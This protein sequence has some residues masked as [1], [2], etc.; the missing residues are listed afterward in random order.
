MKYYVPLFRDKIPDMC[1]RDCR[2]FKRCGAGRRE[3][4]F[5]PPPYDCPIV[6]MPDREE[7]RKMIL[8]FAGEDCTDTIDEILNKL[9]FKEGK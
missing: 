2:Y 1:E 4:E 8:K 6:Q 5:H 7:A 9:G 3:G